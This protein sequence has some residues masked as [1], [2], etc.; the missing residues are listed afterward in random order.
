M[1]IISIIVLAI[2][3]AMDAFAVAV[4]KGLNMKKFDY[5]W[6]LIIAIF[7]GGF[8]AVMPLCGYVLGEQFASK[9]K[10]Y[11]HWVAF[12]LL[13]FIGGKMIYESLHSNCEQGDGKKNIYELLVL[14]IATSVDALIVGITFS[15]SKINIGGAIAIIGSITFALSFFGVYIGYK[16]GCKFKSSAELVGGILLIVIGIKILIEHLFF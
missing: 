3:V 1:D 8:Q 4:G 12:F 2:G 9:I 16:S 13:L 7:F 6:A 11:D 10:A 14:S 5:K 15:F